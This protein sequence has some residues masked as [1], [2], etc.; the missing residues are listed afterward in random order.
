V[1]GH[2]VLVV[3]GAALASVLLSACGGGVAD[4]GDTPA[5]EAADAGYSPP[6]E[7]TG[8]QP[9]GGRVTLTGRAAPGAVI[10]LATPQGGATEATV[11]AHGGW[12]LS[13]P[14]TPQGGLY[15]LSQRSGGRLIQAEGYVLV[16]PRGEGALLRA[17][18]G[19]IRLGPRLPAAGVTALDFDRAG[20]AVISG[21]GPA[22]GAI[23]ARLDGKKVGESRI[24]PQGRFAIALLATLEP[25]PHSIK[26]FGDSVDASL[27][28]DASPAAP[29]TG[30]PIRATP[31]AA[32]L[33]VD[34]MTPG[35]GVQSTVL[36]P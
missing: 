11:D 32:G 29:L 27:N 8:V 2:S 10:R 14:A 36:A 9:A 18:A 7:V 34:W 13:A 28:V 33:R 24:D 16:T 17:G 21:L 19:A 1:K 23:S 35:G 15:A 30:G 6:P 20:A 12:R 22:G 31:T 3:A 5:R 26:V 4:A 25:G